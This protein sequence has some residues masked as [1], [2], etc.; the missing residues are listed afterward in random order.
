MTQTK[1]IE[2]LDVA[3]GILILFLLIHHY[4]SATR[5]LDGDFPNFYF[6]GHTQF[7]ISV[8]FMQCFFFISGFCTSVNKTWGRFTINQIRQLLIPIVIFNLLFAVFRYFQL[9]PIPNLLISNSIQSTGQT[10]LPILT[11]YWFLWALLISKLILYILIKVRD[12]AWFYLPVSFILMLIGFAL[13]NYQIGSNIFFYQ[14]ALGSCFIV[15]FG[16]YCRENTRMYER[17]R[18]FCSI[19][20]PW[21]LALL[22]ALGVSIPIFTAG[23]AVTMRQ[24]PLFLL[25]SIGGSLACLFYSEKVRGC[26]KDIFSF[27]G[28]NSIIIYG[29]HFYPL[30]RLVNYFSHCFQLQDAFGKALYILTVYSCELVICTAFIYFFKIKGIRALMGRS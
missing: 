29:V 15:A 28:K 16:H 5:R 1:R 18:S 22:V 14:H 7:M 13:K 20:Y 26:V 17:L 25:V 12:N 4:Y 11:G 23:M 21:L 30:I 9:F 8:F 3:K 24:I 10:F 6:F 19:A 27:Y 2:Y